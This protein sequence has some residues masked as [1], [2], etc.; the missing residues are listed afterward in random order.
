MFPVIEICGRY[1][2]ER[3]VSVLI[4]KTVCFCYNLV[5]GKHELNFNVINLEMSA[6]RKR[7]W[8]AKMEKRKALVLNGILYG[9]AFAVPVFAV[10]FLL[11]KNG[12]YPFGGRTLFIMDMKDQ[13]MEF[14]AYL[15]NIFSEGNSL[16]YCWSRSMGG[17]FLGL[18]AYYLASP[19]SFLTCLFPIE[20]MDAAITLLTVLKIGLCGLSFAVYGNYLWKRQA[21]GKSAPAVMIWLFSSCYAL[22]SYNMVY[23]LCL[24]WLDGVILLPVI[25][26]GV[27]KL[28]DGKKGLHYMLAL[29]ALFV[30]NYYIGYMA[31]IFTGLYFLYRLT[32]TV[33]AERAA[34]RKAFFCG[35]RFGICT[36]LA[37]GLA[38]PLL[39]PAVKDLMR[40]KLS[41]ESGYQLSF[42]TNF[43]LSDFFGKFRNGVYSSI[44]DSGLPAV[45]C[46]L[47]VLVLAVVFFYCM[48][49]TL[50]EK[51]GASLLLLVLGMSFY[52]K[53]FNLAWHGFQPPVWFPY[54]YA[55]LFSFVMIYMAFR[56]ACDL[57]TGS[58]WKSLRDHR[59]VAVR[60]YVFLAMLF[61]VNLADVVSNGQK[62]LEGLDEQFQYTEAEEYNSFLGRTKPLADW[63]RQQDAGLY[64]VNM[65]YEYSKND[66]M[67][68][69]FHGMTHYSSTYNSAVNSLTEKLGIAQSHIW[70]SGYG[71]NPLLDSLFAVSYRIS[72]CQEPDCNEKLLD[73]GNGAAVY[74]NPLALSMV[75]S[76]PL[77][78]LCP[79]LEERG[80]PYWNQNVL[81]NS[82]AGKD[83]L[84]FEELPYVSDEQENSW[85]YTFVA[86]DDSPIYLYPDTSG[87]GGGDVYINDEWFGNY[88]T[89][90][91]TCSLYLGSY[92]P[93]QEITVRL[94]LTRGYVDVNGAVI[95]RLDTE[96]LE[97]VLRELQAGNIRLESYEGGTLKG[98]I[99]VKEGQTVMTSIPYDEGWTIQ[100]DGIKAEA[101][102]FAGTF[103][104]VDVPAGEHEISFSYVSPGFGAGI[105]LF[106]LAVILAAVYFQ[107][108][109]IR[110]VFGRKSSVHQYQ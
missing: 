68:L 91:T 89:S 16:F 21:G 104:A 65:T 31:G 13:Y 44:T 102:E 101:E 94:E 9:G 90:T 30:S 3:N 108:Y 11:R 43:P 36:V 27:E 40:G 92:T 29:A 49:I 60:V 52:Y 81:L 12:L 6:R 32:C 78:D 85:S 51:I 7:V 61:V 106:A 42:E 48:G 69:G 100:V 41:G 98:M 10:L 74:R 34:I 55:F 46:G 57:S 18:F 82:I 39:L 103:L 96:V 45:Y 25:L 47:T 72:D 50:R 35:V 38:A 75:Y 71:S 53:G 77:R 19:L 24:M 28:L 110:A 73:Q 97:T 54:R 2:Q 17:N 14:Y 64:R 67:L 5:T 59:E 86:P 4:E 93:G 105:C 63:I 20:R 79:E 37:T 15:R 80:N 22:T 26:L 62:M 87:L 70:N 66:A 95:A 23:S 88:F 33:T 83:E 58:V 1:E 84:Y 76:A 109:R 8:G 99:S 56:A 107:E